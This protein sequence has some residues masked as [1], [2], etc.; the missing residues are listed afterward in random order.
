MNVPPAPVLIVNVARLPA[1]GD[2]AGVAL[3]NVQ[4]AFEALNVFTDKPV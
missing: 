3:V 1:S 4:T 2:A